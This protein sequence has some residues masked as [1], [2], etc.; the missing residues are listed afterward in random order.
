MAME[1]NRENF[2]I[3]LRK[4][5]ELQDDN[6]R[7]K[8]VVTTLQEANARLTEE[9]ERLKTENEEL[10]EPVPKRAR[11]QQEER[12]QPQKVRRQQVQL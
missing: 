2:D 7:L 1:F 8:G 9:N 6:E 11:L 4:C 3:L 5:R 10:K 12:A